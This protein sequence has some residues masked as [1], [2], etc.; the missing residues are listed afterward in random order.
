MENLKEASFSSKREWKSFFEPKYYH[1][2]NS[3]NSKQRDKFFEETIKI[4][5]NYFTQTF[6]ISAGTLLGYIREKNFID[7]DDNI[8]LSFYFENNTFVK[9]EKLQKI[10]LEK[11]YVARIIRKKKYLKL[12]IF[13]YGYKLDLC[14]LYKEKGYFKAGEYRMPTIYCDELKAVNFKNVTINIPRKYENY[15]FY[16]YGN[17]R[18]P[19]KHANYLTHES[20]INLSFKNFLSSFIR[21][22]IYLLFKKK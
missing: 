8:D 1:R 17:W 12:S 7:W 6:F 11:H 22:K 14:S 18:T 4:I 15:L 20:K 16:L 9:L 3:Y 13:K 21:H 2:K 19:I 5:Q 10:M